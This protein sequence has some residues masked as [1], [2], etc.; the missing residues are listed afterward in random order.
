MPTR[1]EEVREWLRKAGEDVAV[2]R[3][4]IADNLFEPGCFHCQQAI[5]KLLKA[6]LVWNEANPPRVHDLALLLDVCEKLDSS[7]VAKRDEWE[8][9]TGFAIVARYP[10]EVPPPDQDEARRALEAAEDC[11]TAVQ[12]MLPPEAHPPGRIV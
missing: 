1:T 3:R 7:F 5:E 9:L 6:Y 11:W 8:W 4:A 2:A 12:G 10:S